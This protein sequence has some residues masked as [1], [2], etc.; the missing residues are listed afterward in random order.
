MLCLLLLSATGNS[1]F[2]YAFFHG[3][4]LLDGTRGSFPFLFS[5][6]W[7]GSCKWCMGHNVLAAD[8]KSPHASAFLQVVMHKNGYTLAVDV[9]SVGCTILE[10]ATAKPPWSQFEGVYMIT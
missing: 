3:E 1:L 8:R 9:W 5:L 6:S 7:I 10:M 4:S 2:Y